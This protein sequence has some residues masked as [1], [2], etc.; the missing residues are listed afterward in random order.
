MTVIGLVGFIGSGKNAI[1]D[2]L[3]EKYNFQ[4]ESFANGVKDAVSII[5]GWDR[6]MLEGDTQESRSWREAKDEW[7]SNKLQRDISPRYALQLMGTEGGRNTFGEDLWVNA[8]FRRMDPTK[9]YVISD[10]RFPNEI[11]ALKDT[12]A[13]IIRVQ[14]GGMPVWYADAVKL[15]SDTSWSGEIQVMTRAPKIHYSEW[16]W[17]GMMTDKTIYNDGTLED[18]EIAV[19]NLLD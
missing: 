2:I 9:N 3:I 4:K 13:K 5:F 7:W 14:R 19:K 12:G 15:N 17:C 10:V 11:N 1:A 6:K 16:A 18:L 8:M